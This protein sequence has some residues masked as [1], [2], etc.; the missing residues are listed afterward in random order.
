M[1]GQSR[2]QCFER[3]PRHKYI[4]EVMDQIAE[5]G[6]AYWRVPDA[7]IGTYRAGT[8]ALLGP[9]IS[10]NVPLRQ[11]LTVSFNVVLPIVPLSQSLNASSSVVLSIVWSV[12]SIWCFS[13]FVKNA[14]VVFFCSNSSKA[15][16]CCSRKPHR[17]ASSSRVHLVSFQRQS[18]TQGGGK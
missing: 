17:A 4:S 18:E 7:F 2:A 13:V 5:D 3:C 10:T 12:L 15:V 11:P 6:G 16:K 1:Q 8:Q 14:P 9:S